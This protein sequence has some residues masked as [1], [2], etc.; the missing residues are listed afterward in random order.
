MDKSQSIEAFYKHKFD[1]MPD[2]INKEVG[3]FNA[4]KIGDKVKCQPFGRQRFYKISLLKG[5]NKFYYGDAIEEN[6]G[7]TL[8]FSNPQVPYT[9][10]P[11]DGQLKGYY[12][13]FTDSFFGELSSFLK[14]PI[15]QPGG[16]PFLAITEEQYADFVVLY[17]DLLK[18]LTS[19]YLYK[20]D[21][22]RAKLQLLV[23]RILQ[24]IPT[25]LKNEV[26]LNA[27]GRITTSFIE[28]LEIQFPIESRIQRVSFRHPSEFAN[29]LAVH[30]NHLNKCLKEKIGQTT[31]MLITD[32][33]MREARMLLKNTSW[34]V[35]E[36]AW[37]L[38]FDEL[39]HFVNFFTK[40][41][42]ISPSVFRNT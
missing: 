12:C 41:A 42:G 1:K 23:H 30:V 20:Y 16:V 8:F 36:I 27:A 18:D 26:A 5:H 40:N 15:F 35:K 4:F 31:V 24:M 7:Y 25:A 38:G 32:R 14:Y 17:E 37:S 11:L 3:H 29:Q 6:N 39:T 13:I 10:D 2:T 9:I 28:L 34:N 21:L 33:I 19:P 22:I